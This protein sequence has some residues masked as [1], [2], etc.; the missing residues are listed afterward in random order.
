M[1]HQL[2]PHVTT[3]VYYDLPVAILIL[4]TTMLISDDKIQVRE[5]PV[6]TKSKM[7]RH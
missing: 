1:T 5:S 2:V 4:M 6:M 3:N 7:L